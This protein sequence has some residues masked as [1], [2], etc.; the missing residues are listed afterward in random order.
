M[1]CSAGSGAR[2]QWVSKFFFFFQDGEGKK[3]EK[4]KIID[5]FIFHFL[6]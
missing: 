5:F 3:K 1:R 6:P 2:I 4:E